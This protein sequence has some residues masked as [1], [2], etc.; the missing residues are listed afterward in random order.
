MQTAVITT[1]KGI[2]LT[3]CGIMRDHTMLPVVCPSY[4]ACITS[5]PEGYYVELLLF[6]KDPPEPI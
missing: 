4:Y 1:G 5:C 3:I 2:T 6:A